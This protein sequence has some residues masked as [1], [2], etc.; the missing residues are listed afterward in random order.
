MA[1]TLAILVLAAW[2]CSDSPTGSAEDTA[3]KQS[4]ASTLEAA[5][6]PGLAVTVTD[7][8]VTLAGPVA[9]QATAD[10]ALELARGA[11]GVKSVVNQLVVGP[12]GGL[13]QG[14]GPPPVPIPET[15]DGVLL[16]RVNQKLASDATLAGSKITPSVADG[17]ATLA[18]T[19]PTDAAKAAAEAIAKSIPGVTAV[20]NN[21]QVVAVAVEIVPD[22][23]IADDVNALL[24]TQFFEL[25]VNVEVKGGGVT[26]SGAVPNR[27]TIVQVTNAVRQIKG[28]KAVD[29]SRL[30]VQGGEPENE[31]IGSP[32]KKP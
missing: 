29:T 19:V 26:L 27:N 28:V 25:I 7:G 15:P 4:V 2:G 6:V 20:V 18:G 23:K 9:D 31:R 14:G 1:A 8:V 3:L 5:N 21:L 10:R 24:D 12:G 13:P 22:P 17:V 30:T 32:T 16:A 11:K